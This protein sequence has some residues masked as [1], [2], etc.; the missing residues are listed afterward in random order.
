MGKITTI[1]QI[2]DLFGSPVYLSSS[3][4]VGDRTS[5]FI[6]ESHGWGTR[7]IR[8]FANNLPI[9]YILNDSVA[10]APPHPSNKFMYCSTT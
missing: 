1:S 8:I 7:R 9:I 4:R 2:V 10:I 3:K 6:H 5:S